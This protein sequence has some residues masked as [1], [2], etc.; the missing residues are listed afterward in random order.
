MKLFQI[1]NKNE[2]IKGRIIR[3]IRHFFELEKDEENY[4]NPVYVGNFFSNNYIKYKKMAT[5]IKCYQ[6][7]N[8]L[9]Q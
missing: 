7:K 3:D 6:L 4:Y 5:E 9:I 8:M 2:A 1:K